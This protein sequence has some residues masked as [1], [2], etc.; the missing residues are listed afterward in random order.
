MSY[1]FSM[2]DALIVTLS[3][4]E[5]ISYTLPGKVQSYM[6]AGVPLLVA[7]S[8]ETP[9]IVKEAKCGLCCSAENPKELARIADKMADMDRT[10]MADCAKKYYELHFTKKQYIQSIENMLESLL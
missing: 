8:G 5:I 7:A 6:A 2:A 3:R 9:D 10:D 1:F 4:N